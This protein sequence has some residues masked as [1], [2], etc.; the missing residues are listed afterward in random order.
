MLVMWFS[1]LYMLFTH[2]CCAWLWSQNSNI[3]ILSCKK[4]K[5][6]DI[7]LREE[8]IS[9][10]YLARRTNIWILSCEKNKYLDII[11]R[12][13]QISGYYLARW[14]KTLTPEDKVFTSI[15]S[16]QAV[17]I[18]NCLNQPVHNTC[19]CISERKMTIVDCLP[20]TFSWF[21][22]IKQILAFS[23]ISCDDWNT[24]T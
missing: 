17:L 11:L 23:R 8:Q 15:W 6:Q 9:G 22:N 12:E 1:V 20:H 10:Y 24:I 3:W 16:S 5:Y 13:E 19:T 2:E 21:V 7:I 4:N 14:R 18:K